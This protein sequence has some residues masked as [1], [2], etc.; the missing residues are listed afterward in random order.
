MYMYSSVRHV[1][2]LHACSDGVKSGCVPMARTCVWSHPGLM[3]TLESAILWIQWDV[4]PVSYVEGSTII[5]SGVVPLN[6]L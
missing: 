4:C 6:M 5:Q 2:S 3:Y 1:V